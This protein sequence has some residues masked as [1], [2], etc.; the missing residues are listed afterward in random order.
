MLSKPRDP[1]IP[2][3]AA[4]C[5]SVARESR[6]K[7]VW[8][9]ASLLALGV[10]GCAEALPT[11]VETPVVSKAPTS[12]P[13]QALPV[14]PPGVAAAEHAEAVPAEPTGY[15]PPYP[16]RIDMFSPPS[17]KAASVAQRRAIDPDV[18]LRGI[19]NFEGPR[20]LLEIGGQVIQLREQEQQQGVEVVTIEAPKVTL[21][22]GEKRWTVS[23][24][25]D[26]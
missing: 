2:A 9:T 19:I 7:A 5:D 23:L 12:P 1:P 20:A 10:T 25:D 18:T 6:L 14:T 13:G 16:D 26:R 3:T 24:M 4:L 15:T 17:A 8:L 11:A 21:Q 22:R